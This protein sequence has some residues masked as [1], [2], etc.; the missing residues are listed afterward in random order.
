MLPS[1]VLYGKGDKKPSPDNN[2]MN[3]DPPPPPYSEHSNSSIYSG[4]NGGGYHERTPTAPPATLLDNHDDDEAMVSSSSTSFPFN[5]G[6]PIHNSYGAVSPPVRQAPDVDDYTNAP[7]SNNLS[8]Q[9]HSPLSSTPLTTC[10]PTKLEK[11]LSSWRKN[12]RAKWTLYLIIIVLILYILL[13]SV[14]NSNSDGENGDISTPRLP[15]KKT[16]RSKVMMTSPYPLSPSYMEYT[17]D[18]LGSLPKSELT[19][20]QMDFS[21]HSGEIHIVSTEDP[22]SWLSFTLTNHKPIDINDTLETTFIQPADNMSLKVVIDSNN[23]PIVCVLHISRH[24]RQQGKLVIQVGDMSINMISQDPDEMI[25]DI[26]LIITTGSL[27]LPFNFWRGR[28]M[29]IQTKGDKPLVLPRLEA[30]DTI[31]L[32]VEY[33]LQLDQ[34]ISANRLIKV[35]T[36]NGSIVSGTIMQADRIDLATVNS[37]LAVARLLPRHSCLLQSVNGQIEAT[38]DDDDDDFISAVGNLTIRTEN[39]AIHLTSLSPHI[40]STSLASNLGSITMHAVCIGGQS[41]FSLLTHTNPFIYLLFYRL[42]HMMVYLIS[43]LH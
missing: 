27:T 36:A 11:M 2:P 23:E 41:S 30:S 28:S 19:S 38:I 12:W 16:I 33:M 3:Q 13:I 29:R 25:Q 32:S 10:S 40:K 14:N 22:V 26:E 39:S 15:G 5:P 20:L 35:K 34:P 37:K 8:E 17:G 18:N 7:L 24:D 21:T 6:Y 43:N 9:Q 42:K 31:E 4:Y 1:K